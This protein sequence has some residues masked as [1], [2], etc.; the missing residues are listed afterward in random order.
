[1]GY[2]SFRESEAPSSALPEII[3]PLCCVVRW[4]EALVFQFLVS[5]YP[6]WTIKW[7][8][9]DAE[10]KASYDIEMRRCGV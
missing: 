9:I 8:N 6:G 10:S 5:R 2:C 1:M 3:P 4:G 7:L